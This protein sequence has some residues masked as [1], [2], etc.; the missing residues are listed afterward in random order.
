M[1]AVTPT[2]FLCLEF[3]H[4]HTTAVPGIAQEVSPVLQYN[5]PFSAQLLHSGQVVHKA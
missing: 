1:T 4:S 3:N 5:E 2:L